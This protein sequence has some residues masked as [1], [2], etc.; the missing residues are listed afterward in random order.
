MLDAYDFGGIGTLLEVGGGNGSLLVT[1]LE[2]YPSLRGVVFDR[3]K[4][5]RTR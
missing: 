2:R 4:A 3:A 1:T 5:G